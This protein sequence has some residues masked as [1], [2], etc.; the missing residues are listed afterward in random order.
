MDN[1]SFWQ[2][3]DQHRGK[4]LGG[5]CG[6]IIAMFIIHYGFFNTLLVAAFVAAGAYLGSSKDNRDRVLNVIIRLLRGRKEG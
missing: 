1:N 5:L 3:Y 6:L 4:I 2:K